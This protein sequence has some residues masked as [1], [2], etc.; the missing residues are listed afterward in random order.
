MSKATQC[1]STVGR[2]DPDS[3]AAPVLDGATGR[4][5]WRSLDEL[6]GTDE[7]RAFLHREFPAYASELTDPT[8]RSFLRVMGASLALAGAATIPGCRRPEHRIMPYSRQPEEIIPGKPLFYATSMPLPGGGA[9]GLLVETHEGRPTKI[10]GNPLHPIN[11]GKSSVWAQAS[12]LNLY[13]PDRLQRPTRMTDDGRTDAT[14]EEFDA[15]AA[16]HFVKFDAAR[17]AGLVFLV[18]KTTSPSRDRL[19]DRILARWPRAR[20]LPYEPI[21]DEAARE[22]ARLAFGRPMRASFALDKARVILTIDRDFLGGEDATLPEARG[23]GA[24]RRPTATHG[25]GAEMSR[26]YA[27]ESA[28]SLAGGAADH[29]LRLRPTM[30]PAYLAAVARA[31]FDR[32]GAGAGGDIAAALAGRDDRSAL[33]A[34]DP[35]WID[36]VADDLVAHRGASVV[37][38]GPTLPAEAHALAHA[39]NA[40]LGAIGSTVEL[41]A[42]EGDA[43]ASSL[44]SIREFARLV[45]AGQVD[46][47]V[48]IGVNPVYSAPADLDLREAW[49]RIPTTITLSVDDHETGALST[50]RLNGCHFLESWGDVRAADGSIGVVQPMIAPLFDGRMDLEFLARLAGEAVTD[51]FEIVQGTLGASAPGFAGLSGAAFEKRWR[52][53]LHNGFVEGSASPPTAAA[54]NGAAVASAVRSLATPG[55]QDGFEVIFA[56]DRTLYDGRWAN[57]GWLQELPDPVTKVTWD[58]PALVS[59]GT[60]RELGVVDGDLIEVTVGGRTMTL[61]VYRAPGTADGVVALTLGGGRERVGRVGAGA[62]FNTYRLRASDAPRVAV[63]ASVAKAG[64]SAEVAGV[65]SHWAMEGRAIVREFDAQAFRAHGDEVIAGSDAYGNAKPLNFAERVGVYSH[66]PANKN[67][68]KP[69]Q[70][71]HYTTSPQWGMTI[72]LSSCS[73]CGACTI[74]CQAENNI[75]VVGKIEVSR[76]REMHWIRVDRYFAPDHGHDEFDLDFGDAGPYTGGRTHDDVMMAVQPVACVHCEQAPCETVC[77][78]NA[79]THGREGTNDMAYNR[80]IGTR[81]CLNNCPYKVRRF[82]FFDYATKRLHGDYVGKELLGGVVEN[83]QMIPP[84][85]R[86]K[87]GDGAGEVQTMQYNPNVTVRER[88]VMEKCTFCIQRVNAARV[89]TKLRGLDGI[90]DGFVQTACQQACPTE[91]IVFGDILDST[92]RV[93]ATREDPRS[94]LLLGYLNTRPRTSH[95]ARLR[96]PNPRLREPVVDP[97]HHGADEEHADPAPHD[98]GHVMS[99]P[100]LSAERALA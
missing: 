80:C 54:L 2:K 84:R 37:M 26:I 31:V 73:G 81:Y 28:M 82:N 55:A 27:V 42:V 51:P 97:F 75:P 29:R 19:R 77:P 50:W 91:S 68:Y 45:G 18:D 56:A 57:N 14:W 15:F 8:R 25:P 94:Y 32:L 85:L 40:A 100:V 63:G 10:E 17:G 88:G 52:R 90:P 48:A 49:A 98:E 24:G 59:A 46:T 61:P 23:F 67:I 76:G 87:I 36:A 83:E 34:I 99:L 60:A 3:P 62:G 1:P 93:R 35:E 69:E 33:G 6:A 41:R 72:D 7:F 44:D 65:Q 79:T 43:A 66:A 39:V 96:N 20:W 12:V 78:V 92:S 16:G 95:L 64:G 21:D 11:R 74:A 70:E 13:D 38:A 30:L 9:E 71:H 22:G 53:A 47:A 86:E 58:N 89:E 5:Y 4:R